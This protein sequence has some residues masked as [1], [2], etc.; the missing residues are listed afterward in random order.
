MAG[1]LGQAHDP[2]ALALLEYLEQRGAWD[3]VAFMY[4]KNVSLRLRYLERMPLGTTYPDVVRRVGA[5]TRSR[6]LAGC[7][8]LVLDGT[9]VGRP[10]VDML[11]G[12]RLGCTISPVIVTGGMTESR[13]GSYYHVPKRDLITGLQ[14]A[15]QTGL[16]QIA[17]GM[18]YVPELMQEMADM[19]VKISAAGNEQFG[20]WREGQHDDLVFA[21]ALACWGARKSYPFDLSGRQRYWV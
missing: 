16:L 3:P 13:V 18:P 8:E 19:R 15:M 14:A 21:V 6:E 5:L 1:D 4:M 20:A 7:C 2:T 9:G 17:A 10:V 12:A 11:Y